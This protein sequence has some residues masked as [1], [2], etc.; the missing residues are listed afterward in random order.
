MPEG[1][2]YDNRDIINSADLIVSDGIK[3]DLRIKSSINSIRAPSAEYLP[4][5]SIANNLG[6]TGTLDYVLRMKAGQYWNE[7]NY[8]M[9]ICVLEK[10]TVLMQSS[11]IGWSKKDFFR[12]VNW[13]IDLGWLRRAEE[14]RKWINANIPDDLTTNPPS[15]EQPFDYQKLYQSAV[16][17]NTD[18]VEVGEVPGCCAKCAKYRRRIYSIS[19]KDRRFPKLPTDFHQNCALTAYPFVY[20]VMEPSFSCKDISQYSKRAF[21]DDRTQEEIALFAKRVEQIEK[22]QINLIRQPNPARTSYLIIRKYLPDLAPKS[23]SG[24]MRMYN[25]QSK[26]YLKLLDAASAAGIKLPASIDDLLEMESRGFL[27][28]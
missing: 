1:N 12:I 9:A 20:G 19:G 11:S 24:Y 5:S 8:G 14:W 4:S 18:L 23:M 16:L 15:R 6:V 25:S 7:A 26:N 22:L 13:L 3:Y 10:A 28:L 17:L 2:I 21:A 27:L